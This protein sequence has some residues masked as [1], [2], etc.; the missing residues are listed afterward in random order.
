VKLNE[1]TA[2]VHWAQGGLGPSAAMPLLYGLFLA[3]TGA[4]STSLPIEITHQLVHSAAFQCRWLRSARRRKPR[5]RSGARRGYC[6][7][8]KSSARCGPGRLRA[9]MRCIYARMCWC[10]YGHGDQPSSTTTGLRRCKEKQT[11]GTIVSQACHVLSAH[12]CAA[13]V[14]NKDASYIRLSSSVL[15]NH[16][17][18][19]TGKKDSSSG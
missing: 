4:L 2:W 7:G 14:I 8:V 18:L 12:K 5:Q 15:W 16:H 9:L 17:G 13:L 10:P 3:P 19:S 1:N 6:L 11:A